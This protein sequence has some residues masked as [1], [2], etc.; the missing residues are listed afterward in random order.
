MKTY[1][2]SEV[3]MLLEENPKLRF[4]SEFYGDSFEMYVGSL[5]TKEGTFNYICVDS[6]GCV[7][8]MDG[9]ILINSKW[10][11]IQQPVTLDEVL[12]SDKNCKV[13]HEFGYFS[14]YHD[15]KT[16]FEMLVENYDNVEIKKIIKEGKWYLEQ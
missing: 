1:S 6:D 15:L 14:E 7:N 10:T 12:K 16:I 8:G 11:L 9:N 3:M 2:N 13:E 5:E 4:E